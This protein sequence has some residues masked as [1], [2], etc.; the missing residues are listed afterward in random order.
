MR[1]FKASGIGQ[2][3]SIPYKKLEFESNMRLT[4]PFTS[5]IDY[6]QVSAVPKK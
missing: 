1:V 4:C 3:I 5:P 6:Q 2:G